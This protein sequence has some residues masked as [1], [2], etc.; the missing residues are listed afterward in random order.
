MGEV[1]RARDPRLGRDVAVKVLPSSFAADAERLHRFE[2]EARAA[3]ALNHPNILAVHDIGQHD[4]APYIVSELLVGETLR[5]R[6]AGGALPLRKA[7]E[8]A[9]QIAR[10]LAAAHDKGIVHRD[11][12]PENIFVTSGGSVKILDFGLAKLVEAEPAPSGTTALPT[13]PPKTVPGVV[14]GTVGYMSPEQVR[15]LAV[16]H[17]SDIFAFGSIL[18]EMLAGQR[19]FEGETPMDAMTAIVKEDPRDLPVAERN[20]PPAVARIVERC[21]QK[22]PSARFKSADDLAFALEALSSPSGATNVVDAPAPRRWERLAWA[23][24]LLTLIAGALATRWLRTNTTPPPP[25]THLEIS[26]PPTHDQVSLAISPNGEHVVFVASSDGRPQ[27]WIRSL[28]SG[29]LRPLPG[30][31]GASFPFWSPDS[32]SIGFF[33]SE[34]LNRV[35]VDGG[36]LRAIARAPVGAGG[37][38]N[39]EG[40]I[41]FTPVPDS[42]V[43]RI[44]DSGGAP[45]LAAGARPGEGGNR[46]PQ[47]LPDGRHFLYYMAE[48][49]ARGVYVGTLDGP[50]RRRLF[51]ADAAAVFVPPARVLFI[52]AGTLFGQRF[53][54]GTLTPEGQAVPLAEGVNIDSVGASAVSGSATGSLVYRIGSANRERQLTWFDRSGNLMER[55]HAPDAANSLN[56]ALS[57]DGRV[58]ALNRTVAGNADIW[59][60]DLGRDVLSRFT[61]DPTPDIVPIWSPDGQ[62]IVYAGFDKGQTGGFNLIHKPVSA[63]SKASVLLDDEGALVPLDWSRDGRFVLYR[64][65][66]ALGRD[67]MAT[68]ADIWA[69]PMEGHGKPLPVAQ[70]SFDERAGQ[71]SPDGR[72]VAFESNQ[73]GRFEI[74]IQQFP[75]PTATTVVSNGGGL[76]PRWGPDG[77]EL[78]Y[79]A[80]D[81]RLMA[82]PIRVSSGT[83]AEPSAPIPLF[84][85]PVG[86]TPA[87]GS[88][89]E[90]IVADRGQ[91]FLMNALIQQAASPITVVL[92]WAGPPER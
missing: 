74:H 14:L 82:V 43:W 42:Q 85:A 11:L 15:G 23:A 59:L 47:F 75:T 71:F 86:S 72:W 5:E 19:A 32:R 28:R 66:D 18:Y 51:D 64:K 39:A 84:V 68:A 8:Y 29:E 35:D 41:L 48:A 60:L 77:T 24:A 56:P 78:F 62:R 65:I 49:A 44:P 2:Q 69:L 27:L 16:D 26:T 63:E 92:N 3:A 70:T 38:W 57:R 89:A 6:L 55:A 91:R 46:F 79:I 88:I 90:Y 13:S 40:V 54:P 37:S 10:G 7:V 87:G 83:K 31:D 36:S 21:L 17:R 61:S 30:T 9:V 12:K 58:V 80:P 22:S 33:A 34:H 52:R 25:E 67:A 53:D 73:S 81:G 4:G 1:Y 45:S 20:I 76:Q 50:E